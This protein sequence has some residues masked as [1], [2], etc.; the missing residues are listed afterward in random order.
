MTIYNLRNDKVKV[1][2]L[3]MQNVKTDNQG[4]VLINKNDEWRDE[5]EWDDLHDQINCE[6]RD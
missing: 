1:K 6:K 3:L 2:V 4:R 5:V